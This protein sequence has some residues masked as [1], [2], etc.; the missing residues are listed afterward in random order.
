MRIV[1]DNENSVFN[2]MTMRTIHLLFSLVPI[3]KYIYI[4]KFIYVS[5]RCI[6]LYYI[7]QNFITL[8]LIHHRRCKE[9]VLI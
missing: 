6:M 7:L 3:Y 8:K 4:Y 9:R 5:H 2:S 1:D